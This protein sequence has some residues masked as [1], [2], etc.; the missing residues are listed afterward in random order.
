MKSRTSLYHRRRFPREVIRHAV[1]LYY[2]F[3]LS[4]RDVEDLLAWREIDVSYEAVRRWCLRFGPTYANRL[5]KRSGPGGDPWFVDEV[6]VRIDG[7]LRYLYRAIVQDSQVLDILVQ[8]RRNTKAAA[9]FYRRLLKQQGQGNGEC[10]VSSPFVMP[11][12]SYPFTVR[13]KTCSQSL[14]ICSEHTLTRFPIRSV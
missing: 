4:Y 9:R 3:C 8:A 1:W 6:F 13:C 11:N 2:R 5:R 7:Q 14:A 12:S 10:A